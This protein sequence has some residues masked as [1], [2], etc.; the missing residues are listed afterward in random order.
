MSAGTPNHH[1]SWL[2]YQSQRVT[3]GGQDRSVRL[4]IRRRFFSP[5]L[6]NYRDLIV[7][8]P[9]SYSSS[10]QRYPVVYMQDGQNLFDPATSFAGDWHLT[11]T[12]A[13]L[14]A[15]GIEAIV[16]GIANAG[17]R[18][19]YEYSPFR[20]RLRGGGGG[21]RYLAFV[22]E[23]VKPL[24]D[25][26]FRTRPDRSNT[27]IGGSSMG[28]LLS[29]Y[30][31]YRSPETFGGAAALSPALWFA[32][33]AIMDFIGRSEPAT[34]RLYLDIGLGEPTRAIADVRALR[35]FV[36][37]SGLELGTDLAYVEDQ[38]GT[39]NEETWGRRVSR[40]LPFILGMTP[41]QVSS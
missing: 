23:T 24:I 27:A 11:E 2:P 10:D 13:Q 41:G 28:G 29:V 35:D 14:G 22:T 32:N 37:R 40:A 33:G 6:R 26:S 12:L 21:D 19:L 36:L 8:L 4:V 20:D 18:R 16:V 3:G 38:G 34:G 17:K 1:P 7:A 39:H 5:E 31:L 15:D 25:R 9:R 30:A